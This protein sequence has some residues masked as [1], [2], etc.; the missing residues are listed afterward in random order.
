MTT[1]QNTLMALIPTTESGLYDTFGLDIVIPAAYGEDGECER[2]MEPVEWI[3]VG[4]FDPEDEGATDPN[5]SDAVRNMLDA[6]AA[7]HGYGI[8]WGTY[9]E[10]ATWEYHEV[11]V[12]SL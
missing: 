7:A 5:C 4:P 8:R 3:E 12:W 6:A 1:T 9:R 2:E 10:T 11:E